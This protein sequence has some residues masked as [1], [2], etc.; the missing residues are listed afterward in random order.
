MVAELSEYTPTIW[1][2]LLIPWA[3][4]NLAPGTAMVVN[5]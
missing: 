5:E 1:P 2:L 4:V 3:M